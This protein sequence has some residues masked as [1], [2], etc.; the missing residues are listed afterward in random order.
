MIEALLWNT[1]VVLGVGL[2]NT[3]F[4]VGILLWKLK[5]SR[6]AMRRMRDEYDATLEPW[7]NDE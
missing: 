4:M 6:E 2:I 7:R 1:T 5:E 3:T